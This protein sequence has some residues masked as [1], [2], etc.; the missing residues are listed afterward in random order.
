MKRIF[1][2]QECCPVCYDAWGQPPRTQEVELITIHSTRVEIVNP[3]WC[4]AL[5]VFKECICHALYVC[6]TSPTTR[7][8]I[9]QK[10]NWISRMLWKLQREQHT[11]LQIDQYE[12]ALDTWLKTVWIKQE[13]DASWTNTTIIYPWEKPSHRWCSFPTQTQPTSNQP[14][15]RKACVLFQ[16]PLPPMSLWHWESPPHLPCWNLQD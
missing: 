15:Q 9:S 2:R 13:G 4:N 6:R 8:F 12:V 14:F 5:R 10:G 7:E 3:I 16:E 1:T 11:V